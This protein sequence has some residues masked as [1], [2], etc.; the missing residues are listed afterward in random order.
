MAG[1]LPA[2]I[3]PW[4]VRRDNGLTNAIMRETLASG[5][6]RFSEG[7]RQ[8]FQGYESQEAARQAGVQA[9]RRAVAHLDE[10]LERAQATI[11]AQGGTTH[12]AATAGEARAIVREI[13]QNAGVRLVVKSKSMLTEELELNK[14]LAASGMRVI[15][16]DLGEYIIQLARE[17]PSHILAPAAH[18]N[19]AQIRALFEVD[20]QQAHLPPPAD[21]D[22]RSLTQFARARLR[23][24]FLAADMGITGG[25]FCVVETGT[26][27]LITNEGNADW[28]TSVPRLLVCVVGIEKLVETWEDLTHLIQQPAMNGIGQRLSSYTTLIS[29]PRSQF[30]EGPEEFHVVFVDNGRRSLVGTPYEDVLSCIRCGACLN[31]C[32]VFRQVGGHAYGSVYSGPIGVV[33]TP[34]LTDFEVGAELPSVAC[35]VCHA[36]GEACP[37][38]IDLPGH[39]LRLRQ[40]KVRRHLTAR[41]ANWSYGMWSGA[42]ATP[43][44]YRRSLRLARLAQKIYLRRGWLRNAPGLAHGWFITRDMPKVA[45]ITFHEWWAQNRGTGAHD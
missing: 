18:K 35:T 22:A 39:I 26:V 37:M 21:D 32:P 4:N 9:K 43:A 7:K 1:H 41:S 14:E 36:C 27:A 29:G 13:A 38:D 42:W 16:T 10:L 6:R 3:R 8:V 5:T 12:V 11:Q 2:D 15:E 30:G 20:A 24:E 17:T 44:G 40:E 31:V 23:Q 19:R 45:D 33:E 28:V 34:L 25:N